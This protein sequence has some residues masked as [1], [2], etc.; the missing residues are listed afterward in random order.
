MESKSLL[1]KLVLILENINC[2]KIIII[3]VVITEKYMKI[4]LDSIA[5]VLKFKDLNIIEGSKIEIINTNFYELDFEIINP[6]LLNYWDSDSKL[7]I[8]INEK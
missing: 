5:I 7:K 8:L 3:A 6:R 2:D 1:K 4:E